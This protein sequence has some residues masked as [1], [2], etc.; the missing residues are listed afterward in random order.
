M[1]NRE[2]MRLHNKRIISYIFCMRI[3]KNNKIT[4]TLE[5]KRGVE[6]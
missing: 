3:N 6:P 1:K 5:E 4:K 2:D